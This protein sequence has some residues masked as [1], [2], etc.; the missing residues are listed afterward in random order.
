MNNRICMGLLILMAMP[1]AKGCGV[2]SPDQLDW[3][4]GFS[5]PADNA[6]NPHLGLAGPVVGV[7]QDVLFI[8]GG[9][10]FPGGMPWRGHAKA[11]SQALYVYV[12]DREGMAQLQ[13]VSELPEGWAYAAH[14]NTPQGVVV[15][16]GENENG[17]LA[18]VMRIA[19]DAAAQQPSYSSLPDLPVPTTNASMALWDNI[20]YFAGGEQQYA[21][22]D[23]LF[24]LDL[25]QPEAGW[26]LEASLPYSVSHACLV[27]HE[28]GLYL[29]GGRKRNP[30]DVS[31]FYNAVWRYDVTRNAWEARAP[32]PKAI[33]AATAVALADGELLLI[34]G[35]DGGTFLQVEAAIAAAAQESDSTRRAAIDSKKIALLEGHPGFGGTVWRYHIGKDTWQQQADIP[36][37]TPVTTT[38]TWWGGNLYLPSGEVRAGVR[39]PDVLVGTW[40]ETN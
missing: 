16:G 23:K 11:Y 31:D 12:Q 30:G 24:A 40:T 9:A 26:K 35:D 36:L 13:T 2:A 33:S 27:A 17:L 29:L 10:N 6:G 20:L 21:V 5:L 7:H 37:T 32:L 18:G 3:T 15:A 25:T 1:L 8:G 38:A 14:S 19:W 4:I 39:S 28:G 34:G 22:S